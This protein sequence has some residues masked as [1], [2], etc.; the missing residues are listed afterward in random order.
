M[1]N[2][3][4]YNGST[5][6]HEF[7]HYFSLFHT[8]GP[9]NSAITTELVDGS[10]CTTSGDELCDTPADPNLSGNVT[11]CLY[12]GGLFDAKWAIVCA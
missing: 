11:N 4:A 8:H 3:C 5:I 1:R 12:T 9:T 6:I 10:N 2:S 7:G